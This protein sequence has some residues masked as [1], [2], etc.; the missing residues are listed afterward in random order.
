MDIVVQTVLA[1]YIKM[2]TLIF[3]TLQ[4]LVDCVL[5]LL[6]IDVCSIVRRDTI[7]SR[8]GLVLG[9][10]CWLILVV[11]LCFLIL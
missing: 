6:L 1:I 4:V 2:M 3:V 11:V 7:G 10:V 8:L 9:S 5:I